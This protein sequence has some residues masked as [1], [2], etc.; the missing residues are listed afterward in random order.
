MGPGDAPSSFA[1]DPAEDRDREALRSAGRRISPAYRHRQI[2]RKFGELIGRPGRVRSLD[3]L[4][5]LV[6]RQSPLRTRLA[7]EADR[8]LSLFVR[9][10]ERRRVGHWVSSSP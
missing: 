8:M 5:E 7:K 6:Q 9:A 2:G 3:A 1:V 10:S 4:G